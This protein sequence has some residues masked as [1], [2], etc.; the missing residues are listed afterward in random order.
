MTNAPTAKD[1]DLA[2]VRAVVEDRGPLPHLFGAHLLAPGVIF[3]L[4][5]LY[6]WA[7]ELG[8]VP[9][10]AEW[11]SWTWLPG[12]V[13]YV[14]IATP[15]FLRGRGVSVGPTGRVFIA[16]WAAM[17]L[18]IAPTVAVMWIASSESGSN[19]LGGWPAL[20]FVHYGGAWCVAGL[21]RRKLWYGGVA[22]G[23]F[24]TAVVSAA[25][26]GTPAMWLAMAAGLFL[27]VAAPG[28]VIMMRARTPT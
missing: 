5:F 6:V 13:A 28:L 21:I 19:H 23:C 25:L 22:L 1:D 14:V 12:A 18:M 24:V 16:A 26:T 10:P 15:L 17:A 2:F 20:S 11:R 4:N 3:G 27:F 7:G 8:V 9:L